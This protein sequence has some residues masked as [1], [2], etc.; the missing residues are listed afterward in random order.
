MG[1]GTFHPPVAYAAGPSPF[2]LTAADLDG[3]GK[4][5]LVSGNIQASSIS[6]LRGN[7]DGRFWA[8]INYPAG[9]TPLAISTGDMNSDGKLDIVIANGGGGMTVL[10]EMATLHF[11]AQ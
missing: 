2:T 7:G 5:D 10:Q 11:G 9:S 8:A 1:N 3:D 6:V 4:L